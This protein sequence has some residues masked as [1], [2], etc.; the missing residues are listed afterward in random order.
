V[1]VSGDIC[2]SDNWK[3]IISKSR[4]FFKFYIYVLHFCIYYLNVFR[5]L[6]LAK[7]LNDTSLV[8]E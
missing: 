5:F 3:H 2:I 6:L 8:N 1:I 4:S 7:A